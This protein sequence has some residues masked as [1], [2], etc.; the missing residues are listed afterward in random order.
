MAFIAA[1]STVLALGWQA[2]TS[3]LVAGPV[4]GR[5]PLRAAVR[6]VV[7]DKA[8]VEEYFNN[9]GF[10]RWNRIY[11]EDGEVNKVQLDIRTGHAMTV[12]KVLGWVDQDG[13]AKAGETFCDAGCGVGSLAIPL[14]TR[15]AT[16]RCEP[17][18]MRPRPRAQCGACHE[19]SVPSVH[20]RRWTRRTSVR[21]CRRRPPAAPLLRA[22]LSAPRS[23]RATS[24][25]S[26]GSTTRCLPLS[27][28][29]H[30]PVRGR[31]AVGRA[32]VELR[33]SAGAIGYHPGPTPTPTPCSCT[34]P[35]AASR[36]THPLSSPSAHFPS[37]AVMQVTCIDVMIHYP[38]EKMAEM[39]KHLGSVADKRLIIS[40]APDT[41]HP[42]TS[43]PRPTLGPPSAQPWPSRR[44]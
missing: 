17:I 27:P 43:H 10:N 18:A 6:A 5:S 23:A 15:G 37:P 14:A 39:V 32:W 8:E 19:P 12:E 16:V 22:C 35:Q 4:A 30:R 13:T 7:D 31:G 40:F 1:G 44:R 24:R 29:A 25:R 41:W 11:S 2:S 33:S 3:S 36:Y 20:P 26:P 28:R 34:R 9:E 21:P 42:R 38:P